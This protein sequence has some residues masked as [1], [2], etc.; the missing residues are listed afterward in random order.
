LTNFVG[1][2]SQGLRIAPPE[3][4]KSGY[5]F[6]KGIY[7]ADTISKSASYCRASKEAPAAIMILNEVALGNMAELK[8]D[9]YMEKPLP[10]KNSTKALGVTIPN[11][12]ETYTLGDIL[13]PLGE[14]IKTS[15][16]TACSHNEYIVYDCAQVTIRYL[17]KMRFEFV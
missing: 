9:Q 8:T 4:P 1:I 7:F 10:E 12:K 6:G 14:P 16:S 3:A 2:L 11:P 15:L 5:R 13:V 17:C